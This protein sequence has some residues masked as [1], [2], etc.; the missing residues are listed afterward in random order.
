MKVVTAAAALDS[1]EFEPDTVLNADSPKEIS[2]VAARELRRRELRRHRH[3][4][5]ADQLGQHLLGPGRRAARHR[6]DGRV[7]GAL[8][9]LRRPRARLPRRRRWRRAGSTPSGELV[10]DDFDV[11]RVAIGQGGEEGQVLATAMQMAEVAA[12]VANDGTLMKPTFLQEAK[13]PDGRVIEELGDGDE[14]DEVISEETA[15]QLTEM[16]TNVTEEGTASRPERR[17]GRVRRQDRHRRDRRRGEHQPALVHQLRARRGPADRGRGDDRALHR[18]AS[19]ARSPGPI[20]TQVMEGLLE[21]MAL[22][23]GQRIGDRYTLVGRLGG[24]GMADVWLADDAMLGRRVALKFLHERFAQ[25]AQF[26]ERFRREAQAAAGLQHP[27]V[28]GVYDRGETDGRHWIAMEYVEGAS[29]KDLI[30]RGLTVGEAVEIIRQV[31]A[32]HQVRARA[33]DHPPRPQAAERARRPRGPRPGRRLRHRPRRRLGDHPDRLGARHRAVPLARAGPGPGD[34]R[35]L[36]PLLDRRD[37]LRGAH[38]PGPVRGRHAGRGRAEADLRAAA[39][40]LASSTR[41]CRRRSTPSSCGRSPRTRRTASSRR[42]SSSPRSTRPRSIPPAAPAL[43]AAVAEAPPEDERTP[44]WK[45]RWVIALAVLALLLA[46]V[47]AFA[48]TRPS[49]AKVPNVLERPGRGRPG[50]DRGGRL[51]GRPA[52]GSDLQPG[53]HRHRAG[54]AGGRGG[55][56]GLDR[57]PHR[58]PG[59]DGEG[60]RRRRRARGGGREADRGGAAAASEP[61]Q[62][63]RGRSRPGG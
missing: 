24:G 60:A 22:E 34:E 45:R 41:R 14:Q 19:A 32:G 1:G 51:R 52:A 31:L 39:A 46:G 11:G 29:L 49:T 21:L 48:L 12:T 18:A 26:V 58:Q 30:D 7:H 4:H 61:G 53:R 37:A 16:M 38:R 27:N 15:A 10:E 17:R 43:A 63:P 59:P 62:A 56:G 54:P 9:L 23:Q 44:W 6:D 33:R 55:R 28:V 50:E 57:D 42:T 8:R 2:G 40:A 35:D 13:D 47:A 3:D 25:D 36:R 5:G 20:A